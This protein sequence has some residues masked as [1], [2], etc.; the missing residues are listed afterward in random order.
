MNGTAWVFGSAFSLQ[1]LAGNL[2]SAPGW[3][4]GW[5]EVTFRPLSGVAGQVKEPFTSATAD[6]TLTKPFSAGGLPPALARL[7][8]VPCVL[9]CLFCGAG[10]GKSRG[11]GTCILLLPS[12]AR[13]EPPLFFRSAPGMQGLTGFQVKSRLCHLRPVGQVVC[14]LWLT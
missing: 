7:P 3:E 6:V 2:G 13:L 9:F 11:S 10:S 12:E 5:S 1:G 8:G 14:A 4:V